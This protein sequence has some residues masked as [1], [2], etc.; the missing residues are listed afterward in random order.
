MINKEVGFQDFDLDITKTIGDIAR[1]AAN[2][3]QSGTLDERQ[4]AG[5]ANVLKINYSTLRTNILNE[6][7]DLGW[8]QIISKGSRIKKIDENI[9]PLQDI[10]TTLGKKWNQRKLIGHL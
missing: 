8:V 2:T 10:I 3:R 5:I 7:E 9:P 4:L 6:L 1:F